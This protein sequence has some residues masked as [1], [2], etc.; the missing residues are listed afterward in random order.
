[1]N[2]KDVKYTFTKQ[3]FKR[4][5]TIK[6]I[7]HHSASAT[8]DGQ[9]IHKWHLERGW[10]GI[11]YH[12]VVRK[13]GTIERGRPIDTVGAHCT[14]QNSDSIGICFEG[15]FDKTKMTKKQRDAGIELINYIRTLYPNI[16]FYCHKDFM[17]T[18][19]P[20]KNFP[21]ED[22]IKTD[23]RI[24]SGVFPVLPFKGYIGIYD[25]GTQVKRLQMFLNWYG[26]YELIVDGDVG[27][28]TLAAIKDYQKKEGLFVDGKF[29][30]KS[31]KHAYSIKR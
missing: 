21:Y 23:K 18:N 1:M 13:N 2:I 15:D 27:Q 7:L 31:L 3:L 16:K 28:K 26:N 9:T 22:I 19:C 29:G 8:A 4:K 25:K 6:C 17:A 12:F 10:S 30:V 11:G 5:S 20:G 24:Y 14:N